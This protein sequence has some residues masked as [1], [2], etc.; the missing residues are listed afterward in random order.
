MSERNESDILE[1]EIVDE[2]ATGD[3]FSASHSGGSC[4]NNSGSCGGNSGNCGSASSGNSGCG[5]S[6]GNS[7]RAAA[8]NPEAVILRLA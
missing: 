8:E 1:V 7:S 6:G 4:G 5:N 2:S 3:V